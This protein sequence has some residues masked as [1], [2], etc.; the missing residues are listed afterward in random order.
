MSAV[1]DSG[2]RVRVERDLRNE[3]NELC[4]ANGRCAAEVLRDFMRTYVDRHRAGIQP[5]LFSK[6]PDTAK[7]TAS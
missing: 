4:R 6:S 5:D 1:K 3:F 7:R 2:L